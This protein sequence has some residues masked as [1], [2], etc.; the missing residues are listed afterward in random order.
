MVFVNGDFDKNNSYIQARVS[1]YLTTNEHWLGNVSHEGIMVGNKDKVSVLCSG[2]IPIVT[3]NDTFGYEETDEGVLSVPICYQRVNWSQKV[4]A[5]FIDDS[6][7]IFNKKEYLV[8]TANLVDGV[9]KL[10]IP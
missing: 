10:N 9:C 7:P 1:A 6:C 3:A 4:T 2:Y 8:A 5:E